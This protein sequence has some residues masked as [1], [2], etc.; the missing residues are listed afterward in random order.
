MEAG[1]LV[2]LRAFGGEEIV[3]RV[4]VVEADAVAICREEEYEAAARDGRDP[5]AVRFKLD[6]VLG[7]VPDAPRSRRR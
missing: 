1:S 6:D 4:V 5:V 2:R 7:E 3:R